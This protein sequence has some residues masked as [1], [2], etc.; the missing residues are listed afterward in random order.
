M[1]RLTRRSALGA[2][3]GAAAAGGLRAADAQNTDADEGPDAETAPGGA[4]ILRAKGTEPHDASPLTFITGDQAYRVSVEIERDPGARA[5][6]LLFYNRRLY[7]GLGF[8]DDGFVMHR[9]GLERRLARPG[10]F[11]RLHMSIENDRHIVT[12]RYSE[13]GENWTL[14]G[15]RMEVSGY[16][17][18]VAYDFLSLRP[19]LYVSGEGDAR[20]RNLRY[21]AP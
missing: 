8:D 7:C 9:Y 16:H 11:E 20:F 14:F 19:G 17:H 2:L 10:A 6:V 15:T 4:L 13:D 12:I 18:N 1:S 5:G 21:E 3:A